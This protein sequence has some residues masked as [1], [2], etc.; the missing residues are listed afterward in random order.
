MSY[1]IYRLGLLG[2]GEAKHYPIEYINI[3]G[4]FTQKFSRHISH[5]TY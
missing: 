5:I 3:A 1:S 2:F 4:G